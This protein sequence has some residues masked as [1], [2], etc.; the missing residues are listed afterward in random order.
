MS[1][2]KAML[3][4]L[5]KKCEALAERYIGK[6]SLKFGREL[7]DPWGKQMWYINRIFDLGASAG[8]F[9]DARNRCRNR[10]GIPYKKYDRI[11]S[12]L[13]QVKEHLALELIDFTRSVK[14]TKTSTKSRESSSRK[15]SRN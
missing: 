1:E 3:D 6:T 12:E 13:E 11:A 9:N 10:N 15:K 8:R 5:E 7:Q 14:C 2:A 4:E